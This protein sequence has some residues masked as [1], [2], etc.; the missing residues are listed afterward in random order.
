MLPASFHTPEKDMVVSVFYTIL[1]PMLNPL[2]Y[3]LR[4]K[5]VTEALKKLLSTGRSLL[6]T[7]NFN[8]SL[9][10]AQSPMQ[11]QAVSMEHREQCQWHLSV[12]QFSLC[13][14]NPMSEGTFIALLYLTLAKSEIKVI[15]IITINIIIITTI[16]HDHHQQQKYHH[17]HQY[18]HQYQ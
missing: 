10:C 4:N 17:H 14:L 18:H 7:I 5:N 8:V 11:S 15:N 3:S 16:N 13:Y 6:G 1:T 2:I 12:A 9:T